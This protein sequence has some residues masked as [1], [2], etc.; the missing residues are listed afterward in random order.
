MIFWYAGWPW[1]FGPTAFWQFA[2]DRLVA[3]V[4]MAHRAERD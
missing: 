3:R 2:G 4:A 1:T